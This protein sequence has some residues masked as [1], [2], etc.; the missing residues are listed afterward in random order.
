M[1]TTMKIINRFFGLL[2]MVSLIVAC[3]AEDGEDGAMGPQGPAG[4]QGEQGPEGEQGPAGEQGEQGLAGE[5][6]EQGEVGTANVIYS[7]WIPSEIPANIASTETSFDVDAPLLT[8]DIL[9]SGVIL[10]YGRSA[11]SRVYGLPVTFYSAG[12]NETHF[13]RITNAGTLS[14]R[15]NSLDGSNIVERLFSY[16]RYVLIPGGVLSGKSAT[17]DYTKMT[18][19]E[20]TE[21]FNIQR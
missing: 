20:I 8:D 1:R 4:E 12:Y 9:N 10:V 19:D 21:H 7:D 3:S 11:A 15:I 5:E 14:I 13:F 6:G 17:T 18:Y 2:V 16:Y